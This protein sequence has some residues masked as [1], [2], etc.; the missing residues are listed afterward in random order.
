[1]QILLNP[2]GFVSS[3]YKTPKQALEVCEKGLM[4]KTLSRVT[5]KDEFVK[6]LKG[7]EKFSRI[8]IIYYLHQTQRVGI[9]T[10]PGP[11][12]IKDLPRVDVFASR[13]QYRP[14]PSC[15]KAGKA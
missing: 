11:E 4:T 13:S 8:F 1:M 5:I 2:I 3:P 15:I 9:E 10:S 7:L 12:T 6:G 14:K